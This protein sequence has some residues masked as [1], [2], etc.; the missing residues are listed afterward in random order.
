[1]PQKDTGLDTGPDTDLDTDLDTGLDEGPDAERDKKGIAKGH[2]ATRDQVLFPLPAS[3]DG[4]AA[5]SPT[6]SK[7][8]GPD[9]MPRYGS[10]NRPNN[11][12][13][14]DPRPENPHINNPRPAPTMTIHPR[15]DNPRAK[16]PAKKGQT[17]IMEQYLQIKKNHPDDLVFFHLGDFYE[18][19]FD[20][21]VKASKA[22]DLALTKRGRHKGEEI[23][24][25]GMPI[26]S[27]E[28]YLARLVE[29][30][31]RVVVVEQSETKP[32]R[33]KG[34]I[35]RSVKRIITSG[36]LTEESL[37][38]ARRHN[39][40]AG[41]CTVSH[42][43]A[44]AWLDISTGSFFVQSFPDAEKSGMS[45]TLDSAL[46]RIE[47]GEILVDEQLRES[48]LWHKSE[49]VKK[50]LFL[51]RGR[52]DSENG[53]RRLHALYGVGS[54]SAFGHFHDCELAAAGALV[55]YVDLTQNGKLPRIGPLTHFQEK[56]A[57][58]MD[59]ATIRNLELFRS[60]SGKS[61]TS[62]VA[63]LDQTRSPAGGRLLRERLAA[64]W[65]DLAQIEKSLDR[66]DFFIRH[67]DLGE[68][69]NKRLSAY[70]DL[71]RSMARLSLGRGSPRDLALI[72]D[73]ITHTALALGD[74][75]F[76]DL[77]VARKTTALLPKLEGLRQ[78]LE[79]ALNE[80]LPLLAR[81][82]NFIAPGYDKLL[83]KTRDQGDDIRRHIAALEQS[84]QRM[85]GLPKLK[86]KENRIL[87][88]FIEISANHASRLQDAAQGIFIH[89]QTMAGSMRF[90]T[91]D[92]AKLDSAM[93]G[94]TDRSIH[95]ELE[96]F[97]TLVKKVLD[98][99]GHIASL[100]HHMA[101]MDVVSAHA[102]TSRQYGY[103]R[104]KMD[105]SLSLFIEGG[106][107][108]VVERA[109]REQGEE[110]IANDCRLGR[111][112]VHDQDRQ[113]DASQKG[114]SQK[115]GHQK[116]GRQKDESQRDDPRIW[117]VT[118]PN[119]AGK[120]T[121]LR[122]NALITIMAQSGLHVPAKAARIGI[123]DRLFSRVGAGDDLARGQSTFM[124]EMTETA[125][126]LNRATARSFVI[127]DEVGRGTATFDGLSIA[128]A[129]VEHLHNINTCRT[130][131]ATHY[132]ELTA[133]ARQLPKLELRHM[134]V[135]EWQGNIVFLHHLAPGAAAGSYGIHVAKLAGMPDPAV[136]RA[137]QVLV[138]LEN[139]RKEAP[140]VA[141][142]C[143]Q[144]LARDTDREHLT[145]LHRDIVAIDPENLSPRQAL[146]IL[147]RLVESARES[148]TVQH[149]SHPRNA[150]K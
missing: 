113:K 111:P 124:V 63:M 43:L 68:S 12:R 36:T 138:E 88:R 119:M 141:P 129:S 92:L 79:H 103:C 55:D 99:Q 37:L 116:N 97:A 110:F 11:P 29:Q 4:K 100:A 24:M 146:D 114:E 75:R 5:S 70:P 39:Y 57:M 67:N 77:D 21:A 133:L 38:R 65:T 27:S 134:Q 26:H 90:T 7:N 112:K 140:D 59:T 23:P 126:I 58:A 74:R 84:Y 45:S 19:F 86:I 94:S 101:D 117:L 64:P 62:L 56:S 34:L 13:P 2:G 93:I 35:A 25:C 51:A 66:I 71:E 115:D 52:M 109:L 131:F 1:M 125:A 31:F 14:D 137:K 22:L 87:G 18:L 73:G 106:R 95:I 60:L 82:G 10:G 85:S 83:D 78:E 89:R 123:V 139:R 130:L 143:D 120:S 107:H 144:S 135:K 150:T 122:Q 127:L 81:D 148:D 3:S 108:P 136:A 69:L 28:A 32:T 17:P 98:Q 96:L 40:L 47:P 50:I 16:P 91:D 42:R 145:R 49:W 147:Y 53:K 48:P 30:G 8:H 46:S 149:V 44:L 15:S 20:D 33:T 104:P 105:E 41:I 128:W 102:L 80:E 121:F 132:H 142:V 9:Q 54:L 76:L 61:Q 118:G 72:R 6:T